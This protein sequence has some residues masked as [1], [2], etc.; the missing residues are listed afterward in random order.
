MKEKLRRLRA[1]KP[2]PGK[3]LTMLGTRCSGGWAAVRISAADF[4]EFD[5]AAGARNEIGDCGASGA[6]YKGLESGGRRTARAKHAR[7]LSSDSCPGRT[8]GG[9]RV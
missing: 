1:T 9:R 3:L 2:K 5:V 8:R 6:L 7:G 4:G